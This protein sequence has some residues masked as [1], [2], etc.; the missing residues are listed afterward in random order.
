MPTPAPRRPLSAEEEAMQDVLH[1]PCVTI[2]IDQRPGGWH[3]SITWPAHHVE[4]WTD[5]YGEATL[6]SLADAIHEALFRE[7]GDCR[8]CSA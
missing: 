1:I 6:A 4:R 5:L 8:E 3:G 2:T 7:M